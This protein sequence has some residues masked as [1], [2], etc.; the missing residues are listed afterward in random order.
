M[1]LETEN[2]KESEVLIALIGVGLCQGLL[3][4]HVSIRLAER[5]LFSPYNHRRIVEMALD[6]ELLGMAVLLGME[7]DDVRTAIPNAYDNSVKNVLRMFEE[8]LEKHS[9]IPL[10]E[11]RWIV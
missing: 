4:G 2:K 5:V 9:D 8:V 7:L 1:K 6:S 11:L 10:P 3:Q